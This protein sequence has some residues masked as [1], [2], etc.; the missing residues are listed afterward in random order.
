MTEQT[1][2]FITGANR[3]IGYGFTQQLV[4]RGYEVIAGYRSPDRSQAL[5]N[6]A[7]EHPNLH[8]FEIDATNESALDRLHT[9][10]ENT[11]GK[12]DLLINNAGISPAGSVE[13]DNIGLT[14]INQGFTVNVVGPLL[15]ARYLRDLLREG[16]NP[17]ILNISTRMALLSLDYTN[18][19]SYR[20][21]KVS[22]NMLTVIQ[23][24]VYRPDRITVVAFTPGWVR[25]DMG[26]SG[27]RL[28]VEESV[29]G[30][31]TV[32][33]RLTLDDSGGFFAHDGERL[34]F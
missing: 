12:L 18:A 29:S 4:A 31:L 9:Y 6:D 19:V 2:A 24:S 17:K 28:S 22:L 32:C 25:T 13:L 30:M 23:A 1:V 7:K 15:T 11:F 33:D 8:P 26:G 14:D 5:L 20:L 10:I 3:G 21:S 27:A 34:G 16:R